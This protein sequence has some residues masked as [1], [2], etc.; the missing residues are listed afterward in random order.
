V[1]T[2]LAH[3]SPYSDEVNDSIVGHA[4]WLARTLLNWEIEAMTSRKPSVTVA[5]ERCESATNWASGI[6]AAVSA[7]VALFGSAHQDTVG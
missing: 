7:P 5:T 2:S 6:P 4:R 1:R 3:G